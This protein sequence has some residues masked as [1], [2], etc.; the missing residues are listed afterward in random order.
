VVNM[1]RYFTAYVD[2]QSCG[3]CIPCREG[4]RRMA[5]VM[6]RICSRPADEPDQSA[7]DRFRG[8]LEMESLS[9][10]MKD[11]SLCGLGQNAPN[12]V[13]SSLKYFREEY[14]A[15][16]FDRVCPSNIC[17]QLRSWF[18][19]VDLCTGCSICAKR[20]PAEAIIGTPRHPYFIVQEK[21]IGC[22]ICY[23]VCKFSAVYYK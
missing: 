23:E 3:K 15:H 7:L 1:V 13:M 6:E 11:T 21:C 5:E 4:T 17:T 19:D 20:C 10:V 16:V 2:K 12:P 22:G 14:E 8:V 18:I 9:G